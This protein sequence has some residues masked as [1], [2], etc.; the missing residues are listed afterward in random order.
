L[1]V[2]SLNDAPG[3]EAPI[4][5]L[6]RGSWRPPEGASAELFGYLV[7]SGKLLRRVAVEAGTSIE[8]LGEG[9]CLLPQEQEPASFA[10]AELEVIE[11]ANLAVLD[12]R[13]GSRLSRSP[14]VGAMIAGKA[15]VR[16]QRLAVQAAIMSI[17]GIEDRLLALLWAL[18]ERWGTVAPDG[19]R[20]RVDL[21]QGTLGELVGARRPTVSSAL[22]E[23]ADRGLVEPVAT[24]TWILKGKPPASER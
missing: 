5:D 13:P 21:S 24:G 7:V 2:V 22:S 17:V 16:S 4:V 23:L 3:L 18:A 12:L 15:I 11:H 1:K 9:D 20:V 10:V 6:P 8:L 14:G 19:I